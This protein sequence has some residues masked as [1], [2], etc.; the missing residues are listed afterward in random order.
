MRLTKILRRS[1]GGDSPSGLMLRLV[2]THST[3]H[4]I[5]LSHNQY[6]F[7]YIDW[8]ITKTIM[9]IKINVMSYDDLVSEWVSN[10][11]ERL[12][13]ILYDDDYWMGCTT[14]LL[15]QW[16]FH[17][18]AGGGP[19]LWWREFCNTFVGL[20]CAWKQWRKHWGL[21]WIAKLLCNPLLDE[22]NRSL[23]TTPH[24]NI[25]IW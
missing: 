5:P 12:L 6:R 14:W 9:I 1:W 4:L 13:Q 10:W 8:V 11:S 2:A 20:C 3:H 15:E 17:R 21:Q 23:I 22:L 7:N 24:R 18:L 25:M 16:G 19:L